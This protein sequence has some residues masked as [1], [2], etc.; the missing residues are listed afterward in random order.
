MF[1]LFS[2]RRK[3]ELGE[4]EVF[5]YDHFPETFRNQFFTI[6]KRVSYEVAYPYEERDVAKPLCEIFAQEKG[7]KYIPGPH[8]GEM[9]SMA[10]MELY[11]DTSSDEDFLDFLD[12]LCGAFI[13][14]PSI[15]TSVYGK[16]YIF[17]Q[18]IAEINIRLK[19]HGLGY[20]LL[21]REIVVKTNTITHENIVKPVLKLLVDEE[22]RGAEQEY[23][24]AFDHYKKG[25][26]KDA[27]LNA[28]KA[29]ESTMKII[30]KGMGY[31]YDQNKDTAQKLISI[32]EKNGLFPAYLSN[33]MTG[34]RTTLE[35][36]APTLRNKTSGH[37]QGSAVQN[38]TDEYVEYALNL[39]A[40]N[41][42]F[43]YR[44]YRQKKPK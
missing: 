18:A 13:T 3:E 42:L 39:V 9:N 14:N 6:V 11:S 7:M 30:C 16:Q 32:L 17:D 25:E 41:V 2:R 40:T 38:I 33:H 35:S 43:L 12:F 44:L 10:A 19:Q 27:I 5:T 21:N 36:G 24:L 15:Q 26:N 29:F 22:F 31:A 37:G 8:Y 34:I 20:E 28:T 4:P 1:N 23:L